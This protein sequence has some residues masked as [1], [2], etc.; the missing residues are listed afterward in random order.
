MNRKRLKFNNQHEIL[1]F[2]LKMENESDEYVL[3]DFKGWLRVNAHSI[4][5]TLYAARDFGEIYIMNTTHHGNFPSFIGD[6]EDGNCK[7]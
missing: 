4:N 1:D 3:E 5:G 2:I 6:F 7:N